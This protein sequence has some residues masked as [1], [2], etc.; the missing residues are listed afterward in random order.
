MEGLS[1]FSSYAGQTRKILKDALWD[2]FPK[3]FLLSA[4]IDVEKSYIFSSLKG[5]ASNGKMLRGILSRLGFDLFSQSVEEVFSKDQIHLALALELFQAGLLVHDDIMDDDEVRRGQPTIHK[6][7]EARER[8]IHGNASLSQKT[9]VSL[10]ICAGDICYFLAWQLL[11]KISVAK[12]SLF[13]LFSQELVDVCLAQMADIRIGAHGRFPTLEEILTVY[14]YKTAR[15]TITLPLCAGA[16]LAGRSDAIPFLED[17]GGNLGLLFQLQDD[18][19][20]IFGDEASLGKPIGSDIREGKKTPLMIALYPKLSGLDRLKFDGI[21][22][23]ESIC[24]QDV[25]FIRNLMLRHG[26]DSQIKKKIKEYA[27]RTYESIDRLEGSLLQGSNGRC[28]ALLKDF[29]SYSM[30]RIQ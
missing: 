12:S 29:T 16:I 2:Y 13:A 24:L 30:K 14:T 9:G 5:Y 7:F 3:A 17:I 23:K 28:L 22:G 11:G 1:D 25:D 21:F 4:S 18:M 20:G 10:G 8:E 6:Q 27:K 26:I 19:L 15:Y